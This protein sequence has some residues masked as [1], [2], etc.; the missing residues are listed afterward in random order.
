LK[1]ARL[2]PPLPP[3]LLVLF[4]VSKSVLEG[5]EPGVVVSVVCRGIA[6]V[7]VVELVSQ[8]VRQPQAV[9]AV[10]VAQDMLGCIEESL[11][12]QVLRL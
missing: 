6:L 11:W 9:R 3:P 7:S 5:V 10:A 2:D 12:P 1:L 8:L 4:Q